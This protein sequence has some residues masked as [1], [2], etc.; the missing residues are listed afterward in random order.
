MP[1]GA[2]KLRDNYVMIAC[3][4]NQHFQKLCGL[5]ELGELV[6]D[7]RF[8]TNEQRVLNRK[9]LED[10]LNPKLLQ[11]NQLA[12]LEELHR[13]NIPGGP[14][15]SLDA[16]FSSEQVKENQIVIESPLGTK[17][18]R[19]PLTINGEAQKEGRDPPGLSQEREEILGLI[20]YGRSQIDELV[21]KKVIL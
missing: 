21:S 8:D 18:V 14:I 17:G 10:L 9:S 3:G 12:F 4:S 7:P 1:Y 13:L 5:L 6:T 11:W 20:G 16:A 15:H 2:Y 19:S